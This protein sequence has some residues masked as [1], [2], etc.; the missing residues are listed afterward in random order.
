[1]GSIFCKTG[2]GQNFAD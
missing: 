1:M 2:S